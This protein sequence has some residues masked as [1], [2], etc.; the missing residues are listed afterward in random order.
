MQ[1]NV[2]PQTFSWEPLQKHI[3]VF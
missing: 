1:L 2:L 3:H